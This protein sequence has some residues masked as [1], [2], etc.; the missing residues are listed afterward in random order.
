MFV[1]RHPICTQNGE[2]NLPEPPFFDMQEKCIIKRKGTKLDRAVVTSNFP[3]M[4]I[5]S[6]EHFAL[7]PNVHFD[8]RFE[9][10]LDRTQFITF[11]NQS[12]E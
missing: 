10:I 12:F 11:Y 7:Y 6:P 8:H 1:D 9:T 5:K 2:R 4:Y 3:Y